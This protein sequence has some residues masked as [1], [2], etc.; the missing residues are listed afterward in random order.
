M[1]AEKRCIVKKSNDEAWRIAEIIFDKKWGDTHPAMTKLIREA[2][3]A[4]YNAGCGDTLRAINEQ[5]TGCHFEREE[6][7]S[8]PDEGDVINVYPY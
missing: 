8:G 5:A 3:I 2:L 7:E 4:A 1:Y 6:Q